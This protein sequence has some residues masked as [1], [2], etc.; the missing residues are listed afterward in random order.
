MTTKLLEGSLFKW[1]D[2]KR[3]IHGFIKYGN[4][5]Q[6]LD[7]FNS[8]GPTDVEEFHQPKGVSYLIIQ[9]KIYK[10]FSNKKGFQ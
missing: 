9:D 4:Y 2:H 1:S 10:L 5:S 8:V 3:N 7:D 6:T